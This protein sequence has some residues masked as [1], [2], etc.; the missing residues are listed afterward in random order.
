MRCAYHTN[1][2]AVATCNVCG[3]GLCQECANKITP[4]QCIGC[5][6]NNLKAEKSRII[7]SLVIAGVISVLLFFF[8]G[9]DQTNG[10]GHILLACLPFG[11]VALNKITPNIFLFMP[12]I[13]WLIYFLLK[14][15]LAMVVGMVALPYSIIKTVVQVKKINEQLAWAEQARI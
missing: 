13:G 15:V 7:R 14:F 8:G 12:I 9:S 10:L 1:E 4:P 2:E 11:W 3:K 6:E 5:F